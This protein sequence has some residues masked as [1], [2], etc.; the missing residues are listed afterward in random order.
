M[1]GHFTGIVNPDGTP[2]NDDFN[3]IN[4][5]GE[6]II[7]DTVEQ[8]YGMIWYLAD[9]LGGDNEIFENDRALRLKFVKEALEFSAKGVEIGKG[10]R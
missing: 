1:A 6:N 3:L 5:Y 10:K 8:M 7:A 4:N 9:I 2:Y